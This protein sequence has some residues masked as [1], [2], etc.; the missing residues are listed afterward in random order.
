[1]DGDGTDPPRLGLQPRALPVE[2]TVLKYV[3]KDLHPTITIHNGLFVLLVFDNHYDS[4]Y[5]FRHHICILLLIFIATDSTDKDLHLTWYDDLILVRI[6]ITLI[7]PT[8]RVYL[9]RH[10][11]IYL[12]APKCAIMKP[13]RTV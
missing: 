1:M 9:F 3:G 11:R 13:G 5:L 2:L 6:A 8:L 4:V 7:P 10:R 12:P